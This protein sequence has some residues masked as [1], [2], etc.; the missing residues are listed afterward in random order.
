MK[1]QKWILALAFVTMSSVSFAGYSLNLV[2]VISDDLVKSKNNS[3]TTKPIDMK[4]QK[5]I[6][7]FSLVLVTS[8]SFAGNGETLLKKKVN[9]LVK[10]PELASTEKANTAAVVQF[11]VSE[12]G[13][14]V[15]DK[16]DCPNAEIG[17]SFKRQIEKIRV[18]PEADI[19]GK[20]FTYRFVVEV[21]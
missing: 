20:T 17:E 5:W 18:T 13:Y 10:Y 7:A 9:R 21:Q 2:D 4:A 15:V 11:T 19:V 8:L 14:L 12:T 3:V 6:L 16:I 1:T